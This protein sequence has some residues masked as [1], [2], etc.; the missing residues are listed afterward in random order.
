MEYI[1]CFLL[2]AVIGI[3][4]YKYVVI[5]NKLQHYK[6]RIEISENKI[7]EAIR[8]KFD[9][10]CD[11]DLE[12]KKVCKDSDY[13]KNFISLRDKKNSNYEVDRKLIEATNLI[14]ELQ[15]DYSKLNNVSFNKLL[16]DIKNIDENLISSK[17]FF[18]K[19]T[20]SLNGEIRA[21]PST[22]V[23]KIHKIKV[24]PFFDNKNM[25]DAVLD[26]FKL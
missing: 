3:I 15:N 9:V 18:N 21:F 6:T 10:I 16:K 17:N 1:V 2:I 23:A 4:A 8:G 19:N 24:K 7:D 20:A 26:D 22:V 11:L 13:L 25:Q 5:Y 12:I 14:K